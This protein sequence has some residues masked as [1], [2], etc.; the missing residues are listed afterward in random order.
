M[1]IVSR[2]GED[3]NVTLYDIPETELEK[4]RISADK[5]ARM[6]PVK[7]NPTR[8]D[9]VAIAS[10]GA[11]GGDVEAYSGQDVCYAWQCDANGNCQ[12]VWWYC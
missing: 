9:A 6:F 4:Y 10:A 2:P 5:L 11:S 1:A 8:D 12:Y 7:E 3:N